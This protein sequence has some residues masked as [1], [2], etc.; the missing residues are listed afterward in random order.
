MATLSLPYG[1]GC[2][3]AKIPAGNLLGTIVPRE[4]APGLGA[5]GVDEALDH[6]I[7]SARL[8]DMAKPGM[9]ACVLAS[10]ITRPA[11][12]ALMVPK[13]I[14]RLRA[15]G[16]QIEDITILFGLGI[17]RGHQ[18]AERASLVGPETA[19]SVRCLDSGESPY[20]RVGVTRR[21]TPVEI[22]EVAARADLLVATGNIEYHYFAGFSGGVKAL[23][24][25]ASSPSTISANHSLQTLPGAEAGR[26]EGNPVREDLEEAA[27]LVGVDFILNVVL[28]EEKQVVH[29]VSGHPVEAHRSGSAF[30]ASLYEVPIPRLADVVIVSPGGYPKDI[31]LYQAQKALDNAMPAVRPGGA[32]ILAAQCPEGFGEDCFREWMLEA[33]DHREILDRACRG[34]VLGAHKAVAYARAAERASLYLVS[35]QPQGTVGRLLRQE[36]DLG[37]ALQH[38]LGRLGDDAM[39]WAMPLGGSTRPRLDRGGRKDSMSR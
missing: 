14:E 12:S 19:R 4:A 2:L 7:G 29:A 24:P 35:E 28:D 37:S 13:V 31:N 11:P 3:K 1:K 38:A 8:E 27:A 25:G 6:P 9:R 36:P 10:D 26:L 33:R 23:V 21:G 16:V 22:S 17:H 5:Q 20:L 39:A 18:E 32:V 34:F 15:G 30:L